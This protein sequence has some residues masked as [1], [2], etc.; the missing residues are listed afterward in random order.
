MIEMTMTN[1]DDNDD[2]A[3]GVIKYKLGEK[4]IDSIDDW[5]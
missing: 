4:N 1:N 2:D 5:L 3:F